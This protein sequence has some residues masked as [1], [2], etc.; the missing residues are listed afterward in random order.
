VPVDQVQRAYCAHCNWQVNR[1]SLSTAYGTG[2]YKAAAAGY[3]DVLD[4]A[5]D[6]VDGADRGELAEG[7]FDAE[8]PDRTCT[9]AYTW[10]SQPE[11]QKLARRNELDRPKPTALL[12]GLA[13]GRL[14]RRRRW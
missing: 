6:L 14:K 9:D 13:K 8:L 1:C 12:D 11:I 7:D 4:M 5:L 10:A 3:D 2:V